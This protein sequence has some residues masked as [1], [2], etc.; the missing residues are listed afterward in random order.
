MTDFFLNK[1]KKWLKISPKTP[2]ASPITAFVQMKLATE[3]VLLMRGLRT[4][5]IFEPL[6]SAE[7]TGLTNPAVNDH[8]SVYR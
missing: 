6:P 8:E 3:G 2:V 4:K 5:Q 7:A 1:S